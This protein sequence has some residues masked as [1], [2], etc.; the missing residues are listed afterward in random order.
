M[1]RTWLSYGFMLLVLVTLLLSLTGYL[2]RFSFLADLTA[3]FKVHYAIASGIT[4]IFFGLT[5]QTGWMGLSL[6][7]LLLNLGAIVP[8][9]LPAP[10]AFPPAFSPRTLKVLLSNVNY[11]NRNVSALVDLIQEEE[12]DVVAI[13]EA[14]EFWL[15]GLEPI[16][17]TLP[18]SFHTPRSK[19]F[20]TA[21]D[22]ALYSRFPLEMEPVQSVRNE[23]D[24]HLVATVNIPD[25]PLLVAAIHPPPPINRTLFNQR[26]RELNTIGEY[27]RQYKN[28][29][30]TNRS[31]IAIGDLN[32]TMWSPNYHR[33]VQTSGLKNARKG[34]GILPTWHADIP[35]LD[36]P[37]DHCLVSP[38]IQVNQIR[39]GRAIGS[40]HLPLV[41]EVGY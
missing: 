17:T 41:V 38:N 27:I 19:V 40:D 2:G 15:Q 16:E 7:C 30:T 25:R 34:F 8:W 9:Y 26:N 3:H 21:L 39:T 18:Y 22:I 33:F 4:L 35:F 6:V 24:F 10:S 12:P 29:Q 37:I 28:T 23:K 31:A 13:V 1:K 32:I 20:G 36:I 14:N 5:R 11:E